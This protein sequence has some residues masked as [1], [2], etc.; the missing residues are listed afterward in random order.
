MSVS[1]ST[2]VASIAVPMFVPAAVFSAMARVA[3]VPSVKV[4]GS[5]TFVILIVTGMLSLPPLLSETETVTVYSFF[6]S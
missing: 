3:L 6:V 2:S 5:L 1:P 4:G